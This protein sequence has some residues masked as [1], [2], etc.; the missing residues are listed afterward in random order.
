LQ[1]LVEQVLLTVKGEQF[2][3]VLCVVPFVNLA[4]AMTRVDEGAKSEARLAGLVS[5]NRWEMTPC[6]KLCA[7][8]LLPTA[9]FP[10]AS[11]Q[12]SVTAHRPLDQAVVS[13]R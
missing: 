7:S 10:N 13:S 3:A 11:A 8:I 12:S 4:A 1:S 2:D 6:G 9:I 5:R